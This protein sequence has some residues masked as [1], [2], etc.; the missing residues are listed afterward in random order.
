LLGLVKNE[1]AIDQVGGSQRINL[2]APPLF[3]LLAWNIAVYAV[4][5]FGLVVRYGDTADLG[6]MRSLLIR[7]AGGRARHGRGELAAA[8]AQFE[9]SSSV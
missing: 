5:A 4:L 2:L 8:I 3:A 6:P 1:L 7:I 9:R